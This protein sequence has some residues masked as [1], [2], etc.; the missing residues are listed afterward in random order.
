[1]RKD[2]HCYWACAIVEAGEKTAAS[3]RVGVGPGRSQQNVGKFNL[4]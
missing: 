2:L 4:S 1:M 3:L